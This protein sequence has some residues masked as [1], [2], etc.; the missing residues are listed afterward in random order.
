MS[1][2]KLVK[3]YK[4]INLHVHVC[5]CACTMFL[6][7]HLQNHT[8]HA[9]LWQNVWLSMTATNHLRKH[10]HP[11]LWHCYLFPSFLCMPLDNIFANG[12]A[13]GH[14]LV[15]AQQNILAGVGAG[16]RLEP[17]DQ[18]WRWW[19]NWLLGNLH[20]WIILKVWVGIL[21]VAAHP[22]SHSQ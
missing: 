9:T 3:E 20:W 5:V 17:L 13:N 7:L 2:N 10:K 16:L 11:I 22:H 15:Q 18:I 14:C 19:H 6:V 8:T 12:F 1:V 21:F 4:Q